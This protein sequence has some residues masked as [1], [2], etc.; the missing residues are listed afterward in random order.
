MAVI[1]TLVAESLAVNAM[2]DV[3]L[4]LRRIQRISAWTAEDGQ[5]TQWTLID[6]TCDDDDADRFARQLAAAMMPGKW[7]TDY[8]TD[9]TKWVVFAGKIYR[10][11]RTDATTRAEAVAYARRV[12]V[13]EAQLDWSE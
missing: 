9:T 7:Y 5:P 1:G 13:P 10:Y 6:F 2:I 4:T 3:P 12:G 8:A 11:P